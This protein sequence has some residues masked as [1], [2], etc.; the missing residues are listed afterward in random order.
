[1]TVADLAARRI[2]SIVQDSRRATPGSLF[3]C[4]PGTNA[5]DYLTQATRNGAVFAIV[6]TKA[7]V[8]AANHAGIGSELWPD[9]RPEFNRKTCELLSAFYEHPSRTMKVIGVTGT[10]GKTTTAWLLQSLMSGLV[11]PTAYLGTLGY[12]S[13]AAQLE[14]ENTT[15]FAVELHGL[16]SQARS[17]G[18]LGL[19]MEVS[20]H[21]L[22]E[23]RA[24][25]IE[26]D[27]AVFTN[28]TEDHL[29]H[30]VTMEAY[31]DAKLR[32]FTELPKDSAKPF[33][34]AL[35]MDDPYGDYFA[36][37]IQSPILRY[38]TTPGLDL[39]A[40]LLSMS[41][42]RMSLRFV[43]NG[44]ALL[45]SNV[46]LGGH[47]N[48]WNVTSAVAGMLALGY[49]LEKIAPHLSVLRPVP[50][51]FESL[52]NE[53]GIGVLVDYAHTP[54]ALLKLL[55]TART[56]TG[57]RLITVFGCGG[58]RQTTKRAPMGRI[59]SELSE[60]SIV[61]SDNP[62]TENPV[63]IAEEIM[64]GAV[65]GSDCRMILDREDA[66]RSAIVQARVGDVVVI[67]GKG[68]EEYQIIGREKF[69]LSD[70]AIAL[71]CLRERS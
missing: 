40:E 21:A 49:S 25:C 39:S 61:T 47:F 38:G 14:L 4:V 9:N 36:E 33:V 32:L 7:G 28:L 37:H 3:V 17:E 56:L 67:A 43:H 44:E 52:P 23:R 13:L 51:R 22:D 53:S 2:T 66:I 1:M 31:A 65:P 64:T 70:K 42:D 41:V 6:S 34:A 57:G 30:H 19:A 11:G 10:N 58:D 55:Q 68:H 35:N 18:C 45:E 71:E 46:H 48:F 50:G 20:S 16:V 59:A 62:R 8:E 63:T 12:Q 27:A 5:V 69:P 24:D 54:D 29:D 26:F 15:P 60:V